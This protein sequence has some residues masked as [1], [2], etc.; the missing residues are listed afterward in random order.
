MKTR[1]KFSRRDFLKLSALAAGSLALNPLFQAEK[2]LLRTLAAK[3]N[4]DV[5]VAIQEIDRWKFYDNPQYIQSLL[6]F[7][8]LK[9]GMAEWP[10]MWADQIYGYEYLT[11]LGRFA[12]KHDMRFSLDILFHPRAF[13]KN[14]KLAYLNTAGKEAMAEWIQER[15]RKFFAVPYFTDVQFANEVMGASERDPVFWQ[16]NGPL[17]RAYGK[18]WPVVAYGLAWDEAVKTGRKVGQDVTF[19]Y[20]TGGLVEVPDSNHANAEYQYLSEL[21]KQLSD[22]YGIDRPFAIGLEYHIHTGPLPYFNGCWGP[23]SYQLEKEALIEHFQRFNELGDVYVNEFSVA[24]TDDPATKKEALH[25]VLEAAIESKTCKRFL[26]FQ[27][28][29]HATGDTQNDAY[30]KTCTTAN[31]FDENLKP[32][33]MFDEMVQIFESYQ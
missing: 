3:L 8:M 18:E 2:P 6:Q 26:V 15:V 17:Y 31:M 32:D 25:T 4:M 28:F 7:S 9:D 23:G 10:D 21:K 1:N 12:K 22:R 24:G 14:S 20:H 16:T 27:P 30:Q 33:F 13:A 11:Q 19:V 29:I 5:G